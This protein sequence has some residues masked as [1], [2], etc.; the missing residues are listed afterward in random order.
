MKCG[1]RMEKTE[2][3][4]NKVS[5]SVRD[6]MCPVCGGKGTVETPFYSIGYSGQS[7]GIIPVTCYYCNGSGRVKE[8]YRK[9]P[10]TGDK[11]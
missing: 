6:V 11:G 3:T 9:E 2:I 10:T 5:Y 8:Y 1:G 7:T 4:W